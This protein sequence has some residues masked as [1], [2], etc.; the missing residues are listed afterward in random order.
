AVGVATSGVLAIERT[1]GIV[2]ETRHKLMI[3]DAL[4]ARP[5]AMQVIDFVRVN[6]PLVRDSMQT[7]SL[8]KLEN[9]VTFTTSSERVRTLATHIPASRQVLDDM[10]ELQGF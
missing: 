2:T 8:D 6:S 7:E 5:T 4:T 10:T 1:P 9:A 3:R